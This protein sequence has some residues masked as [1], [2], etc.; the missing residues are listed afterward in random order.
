M[1]S[2]PAWSTAPLPSIM[3]MALP[4]RMGIYKGRHAYSGY[5]EAAHHEEAVGLDFLQHPGHGLLLFRG[6]LAFAFALI[7]RIPFLN[8][9]S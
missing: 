2:T 8:W 7:S 9:L 6:Q 1:R 3:S 5:D 4:Q